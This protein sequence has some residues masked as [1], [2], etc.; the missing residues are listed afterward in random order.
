MSSN[1]NSVAANIDITYPVAGQDNSS[2]GFRDNFSTIQKAFNTATNEITTLQDTAVLINKSN[3]FQFNGSLVQ[4]KIQN[5]GYTV[6]S[7]VATNGTIELDYTQGSYYRCPIVS[8]STLQ[9]IKSSWPTLE[10]GVVAELRIEIAPTTSTSMNINF[11]A[12]GGVLRTESAVTLPYTSTLTDVTVWDL[13]TIDGG[14]TVFVNH[15]GRYT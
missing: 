4:A 15:V 9:I 10:K 12:P 6:G 7:T 1:I 11:A 3:D 8:T 13:W 5:S 2:Q 14:A